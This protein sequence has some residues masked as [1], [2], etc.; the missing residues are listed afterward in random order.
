MATVRK[1]NTNKLNLFLDIGV[2]LAFVIEMEEHFTGLRNH[3]LLGLAFTIALGIHI[4]LHW[5]WVV[6]V[7]KTFFRKLFH[8][9]R[10]NYVLN[11]ALFINML[12]AVGTGFAISRTLGLDFDIPR[13]AQRGWQTLHVTSSRLTLIVVAL[14]VALHWKWIA[15]HAKKYLFTFKLPRRQLPAPVNSPTTIQ[16]D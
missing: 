6:S 1:M 4:I 16:A 2:A 5:A 13:S 3:E 8:G 11:L 7:T 12:V 14:H 10:L 9:S 15:A